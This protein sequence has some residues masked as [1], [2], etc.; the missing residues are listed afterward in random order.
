[1][2]ELIGT[3]GGGFRVLYSAFLK[4]AGERSGNAKL[5]ELSKPML[6][7]GELWREFA[8][9]AGRL[10][11]NRCNPGETYEKL[12]AILRDIAAREQS[13]FGELRQAVA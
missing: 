2:Q 13:L 9:L 8:S 1:M 11:K 6:E 4:Q 3:G 12:P 10:R 5:T 7:T